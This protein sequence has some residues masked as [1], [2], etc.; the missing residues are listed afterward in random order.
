[1]DD[2]LTSI[3][4]IVFAEHYFFGALEGVLQERGRSGLQSI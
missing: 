3:A 1:M 2:M 4:L